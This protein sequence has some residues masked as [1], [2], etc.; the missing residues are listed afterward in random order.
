MSHF[1]EHARDLA[2]MGRVQTLVL[3]NTV[4]GKPGRKQAL[5][6]QIPIF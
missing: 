5:I 6:Q 4:W 3:A 1:A 2:G